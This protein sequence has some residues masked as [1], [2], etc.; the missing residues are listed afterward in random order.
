MIFTG[1]YGAA[2]AVDL[3]GRS[4]GL[5]HAISGHNSYWWWGPA[6]ARNGSTIIAVDLPRPYLRTIFSEVTPAG[7]VATPDGVWSEERGD[8]IWICRGQRL[9]W[10]QA[11]PDARIER[12]NEIFSFRQIYARLTADGAVHLR[13]ERCWDVHKT[14]A[15]QIGGSGETGDVA[16][17]SAAHRYNCGVTIGAGQDQLSRDLLDG[18]EIFR[19]FAVVEQH[20]AH[21]HASVGCEER[22]AT[23]DPNVPRRAARRAHR[24]RWIRL[25][26]TSTRQRARKSPAHIAPGTRRWTKGCEW[27]A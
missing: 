1:D 5:P 14:D 19:R 27:S 6:G 8:P 26:A 12:A 25:G 21:R 17:D 2:G 23:G 16:D 7:T 11:W 22:A 10:A 15:A 24:C 13:Y 9:T 4:Y 20:G 18:G 3:Y